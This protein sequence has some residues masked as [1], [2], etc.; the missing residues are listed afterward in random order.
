VRV[1]RTVLWEGEGAIP[2]PDPIGVHFTGQDKTINYDMRLISILILLCLTAT[3]FGQELK[4]TK[5]KSYEFLEEY[6]VLSSDKKVRHG[7]Y[8]KFN[9]E[10]QLLIQGEY[11]NGNKAGVWNYYVSDKLLHSY[12]Y[13]TKSL[14]NHSKQKYIGKAIIDGQERE[15]EFDSGPMYFGL[16]NELNIEF[17]KVSRYPEQAKRMGI[18]GKI[19]V[20]A[21]ID[22]NDNITDIKVI[23]GIM[24]ECDKEV[25][26]GLEKME[27][28]WI[29]GRVKG[30]PVKSEIFLVFEFSLFDHTNIKV[31]M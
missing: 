1:S 9:K 28:N 27:K 16:L 12:N 7:Q 24:K 2:L 19:L 22:E 13:S 31:T 21:W 8:K 17:N 18:E 5:K 23:N 14:E 30:K 3:A 29:A 25:I 20:S 4:P 10:G 6:Y 11:N 15:I 26:N